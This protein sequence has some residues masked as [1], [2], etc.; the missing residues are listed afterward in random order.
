MKKY[1]YI[2]LSIISLNLGA[3][4][5]LI[6]EEKIHIDSVDSLCVAS[7]EII[8]AS[9]DG[10]IK[11]TNKSESKIIGK[12]KDWVRKVICA[13]SNIISA[14]NDG[15]ISIWSNYKKLRSVQAHSWWVTDIALNDEKIVS[16]SLDETVKVWSY[17]ELKLL[18]SHKIFGSNKHYSVAVNNGKAFIGST[19][20]LMYVLDLATFEWVNQRNIANHHSILLSVDKSEK[21]VYFGT[22]DGHI[23]KIT[24]TSPYKVVTKKK[25][26]NFAVKSISYSQ[27]N[28]FAGDDNGVIWRVNMTDNKKA[29][30]LSKFPEAIHALTYDNNTIYAGY[31]N[32]YIRAFNNMKAIVETK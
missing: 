21:Y 23:V 16:V 22:S 29:S 11:E 14:S 6:Y 27:N 4:E 26:S 25:I 20:G 18:Y 10:S 24:T 13:G 2:I 9:F 19:H 17:P 28:I 32:G 1:I 8:S 15:A 5:T 3:S 30:I 31:D 7:K 12:H